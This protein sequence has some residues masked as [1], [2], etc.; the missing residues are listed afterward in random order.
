MVFRPQQTLTA[1]DLNRSFQ[2]T[3]DYARLCAAAPATPGL[4]RP[5]YWAPEA[6]ANVVRLSQNREQVEVK[7][8]F[9]MLPCGTPV[10]V[11]EKHIGARDTRLVVYIESNGD[12]GT[13]RESVPT[14]ALALAKRTGRNTLQFVA[15]LATLDAVDSV[16]KPDARA[17]RLAEEWREELLTSSTFAGRGLSDVFAAIAWGRD[18]APLR[19][20]KL[21]AAARAINVC[22]ADARERPDKRLSNYSKPPESS[23]YGDVC[24]WLKGWTEVIGD[25]ALRQRFFL[26]SEWIPPITVAPDDA[27]HGGLRA[28]F[29]LGD[30]GRSDVELLARE[31]LEQGCY[32]FGEVG[33]R[34][35]FESDGPRPYYD[36]DWG[37]CWKVRLSRPA[38]GSARLYVWT[39][40]D[41]KLRSAPGR[42]RSE[43]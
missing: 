11:E 41:V 9:A 39:S 7:A 20:E 2:S 19:L 22:L 29:D 17:T 16:Q 6:E 27:M 42:K 32:H 21:S 33:E 18:S 34:Q 31:S 43:P 13:D 8:L 23:N 35:L 1:K 14:G 5:W 36:P 26:P 37:N 38:E 25:R 4:F 10:A 28:C 30:R 15:P 12:I 3:R 24:E 40:G